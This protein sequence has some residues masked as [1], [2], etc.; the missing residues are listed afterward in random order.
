MKMENWKRR[1]FAA[2][3]SITRRLQHYT[4]Q[5]WQNDFKKSKNQI[6]LFKLDFLV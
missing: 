3:C 6:F 4:S 5:G 2:V 1:I